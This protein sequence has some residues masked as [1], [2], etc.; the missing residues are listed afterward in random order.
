ALEGV[1]DVGPIVAK[2]IV[3]FFSQAHNEEVINNLLTDGVHWPDVE[4][5]T[6]QPLQGKTFVI[7]G[8]L[9]GMKREEVKQRLLALGA[10][11]SGSV[12]KKTDYV[13]AGSE[14]GSKVEKARQLDVEILDE[15][16]LLSLIK[17][18]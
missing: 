10:K 5:K 12:S 13:I 16:G 2:H 18:N 17:S 8:T 1:T 7:T 4:I 11:V 14:P 15:V 3:T 9:E 6:E